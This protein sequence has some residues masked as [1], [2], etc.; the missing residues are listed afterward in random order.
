MQSWYFQTGAEPT[1]RDKKSFQVYTKTEE[2]GLHSETLRTYV[3]NRDKSM[4]MHY[5]DKLHTWLDFVASR[6]QLLVE[7][8]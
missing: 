8:D 3:K 4:T 2:T 1:I 6:A 5:D 7:S